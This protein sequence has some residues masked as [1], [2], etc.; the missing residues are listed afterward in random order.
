MRR[1]P[2]QL[3]GEIKQFLSTGD[4]DILFRSWP[5]AHTLEQ[6]LAGKAAMLDA[7]IQELR[8]R[9]RKARK[10]VVRDSSGTAPEGADL[11]AFTSARV[12]PM[13][14]GLFPEREHGPVQAL[15]E[16]SVVFLVPDRIES[17]LRNTSFLHVAWRLANMYLASIGAEPLGKDEIVAVGYA[18]EATCYVT[19]AYFSEDDPFADYVVHEAAHVFHHCKRESIGLARTRTREWLL[20]I[21]Y[22]KRETFAYACEAYSRITTLA[23]RPADRKSLLGK[24]AE[25]P[26]PPDDRVDPKKIYG[27]LEEALGRRN[28][29]KTIL[30]RCSSVRR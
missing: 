24:L 13:V 29:W 6:C 8:R 18:E 2:A 5:G 21:D 27:I 23:R 1:V 15:L 9:E 3:A 19:L 17:I 14:R 25:R 12:A 30:E 7:L 4:H 10:D 26:P 22:R 16:R 28:G 11:V 20:P